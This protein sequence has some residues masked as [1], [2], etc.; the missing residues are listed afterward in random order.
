MNWQRI[1]QDY[2]KAVKH[3]NEWDLYDVDMANRDLYNFFDVQ[4]IYISIIHNEVA[5]TFYYD[6][7]LKPIANDIRS[8]HRYSTRT[9]AETA[10]FEKAFEILE[11]KL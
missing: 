11:Q 4:E 9:E 3:L 5:R 6:I 7:S 2:P 1:R 10:A 8:E